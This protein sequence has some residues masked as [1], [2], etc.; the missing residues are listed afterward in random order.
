MT[1]TL[2]RTPLH[3]S[4]DSGGFQIEFRPTEHLDPVNV[5]ARTPGLRPVD[6]AYADLIIFAVNN[7][8]ALTVACEAIVHA[9]KMN[10]PALGAVAATLAAAALEADEEQTA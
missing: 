2:A 7:H 8:D 9:T 3:I 4:I 5:V 6:K 1:T 10:D